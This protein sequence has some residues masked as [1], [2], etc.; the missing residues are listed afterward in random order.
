M[1]LKE[2]LSQVHYPEARDEERHTVR[3]EK[4]GE[5]FPRPHNPGPSIC[6]A[7][8]KLCEP[9]PVF[10]WKLHYKGVID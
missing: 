4:R 9:H 6:S 5:P 2:A 3:C 1:V 7:L 10:S 8:R